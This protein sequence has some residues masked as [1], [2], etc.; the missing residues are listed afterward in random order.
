MIEGAGREWVNRVG[1][2]SADEL[3]RRWGT[4]TVQVAFSPDGRYQRFVNAAGDVGGVGGV[5]GVGSVGG[6][7]GVGGDDLRE[8]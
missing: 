5:G 7:G 4:Q 3:R 6:V 2:C 8:A 1:G